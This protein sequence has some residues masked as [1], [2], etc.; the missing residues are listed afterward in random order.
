MLEMNF[1]RMLFT[2]SR[3]QQNKETLQE[4]LKAHPEIKFVSF[5][6]L[7]IAGKDTDERI[8]V[9]LF[10]QDIEEMLTHGV[11]TDGSSVDLPHIAE[12][13]DAKVDMI[14]DMDVNWFVDYNYENIDNT[15]GLPVG[16]L[17]IPS[18]LIHNDKN[19]VG[20]RAIL[21]DAENKFKNDLM[22]LIKA[23]PYALYHTEGQVEADDISEIR[24]TSATELEFWVRTPDDKADREELSTSQELKEQYWKRTY[25]PVRTAL[26]K[27]LEILD[28]YGLNMEMGHKEVGGVKSKITSSGHMDHIMEQ[29]EIDWKYSSPVQA[30]DNEKLVK[31]VVRDVFN[32]FGLNTTFKAKPV[33]GVAGSGEHTHFGASAVLKDGRHINL[34]NPSGMTEEFMSPIGYGSLMGILKNYE[35]MNPFVSSSTNSLKRLKPGYE[36]PICVVTSLGKSPEEPSRNR[37]VLIGLVRDLMSPGAT[38]F[39]L[40]SPN[41]KSNTYL[42]LAAGYMAMLDGI[43]AALESEKT[44]AELEI[45][46]SKKSGEKD[47]YLEKDREYRSEKNVFEDYSE[48]ERSSKFGVPPKTV[49]EN[50]MA[51][52]LYPDKVRAVTSGIMDEKSVMSYRTCIINDWATE[53]HSRNIPNAMNDIKECVRIHGQEDTDYD[54]ACWQEISELR[55]RLAKD[56]LDKKSLLTQARE[57]LDNGDYDKA[58]DLQIRIQNEVEELKLKYADYKRNL[59]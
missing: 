4:I 42:V 30:A 5:A 35:A 59:F 32:A 18:M 48:E 56:S 26:E 9:K 33:E 31:Y 8:P 1:D 27:S 21:K 34:F 43:R 17:R 16:T 24:L 49:W 47:F 50:M 12:L 28:R 15:T 54:E 41:P 7:D 58:S 22:E 13:N 36:A 11:Q 25:G 19:K 38:R 55:C 14:P 29:L 39:E 6:G 40:R 53:Y 46:I 3:E 44:P 2:I 37:T 10:R 57:A 20:A 45:S 23:H 52:E 51:F